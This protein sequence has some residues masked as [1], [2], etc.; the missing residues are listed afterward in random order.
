MTN[1]EKIQKRT[2][3][4]SFP[5]NH[6]CYLIVGNDDNKLFCCQKI[7][8]SSLMINDGTFI[9]NL[10]IERAIKSKY[11][12]AHYISD[13]FCGLDVELKIKP[14]FIKSE[15]ISSP[16]SVCSDSNVREMCQHKC[17]NK[18][19]CLHYCCKRGLPQNDLYSQKMVIILFISLLQ[20]RCI[21][22]L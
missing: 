16:Q 21:F 22:N 14:K 13:S 8:D 4:K 7:S 19:E 18:R 3:S 20:K 6:S 12:Y 15:L 17:L 5:L 1:Y 9:R 10:E 11:V 2:T